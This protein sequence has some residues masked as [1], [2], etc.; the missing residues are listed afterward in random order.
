VNEPIKQHAAVSYN[1]WLRWTGWTSVSKK[2]SPISILQMSDV[3][4]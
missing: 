4:L 2:L 3:L 1:S